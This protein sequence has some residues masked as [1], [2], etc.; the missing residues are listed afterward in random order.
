M[1]HGQKSGRVWDVDSNEYVDMICGLLPVSLGYCDPNIDA[2]IK[3][4]LGK[5][6]PIRSTARLE[7]QLAK[8]FAD[9]Y[10]C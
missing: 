6:G 8:N 10:L 2:A 7:A 4:Q 5:G 9:Y 1:T 3:H